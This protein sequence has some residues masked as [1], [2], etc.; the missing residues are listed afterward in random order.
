[1]QSRAHPQECVDAYQSSERIRNLLCYKHKLFG[2]SSIRGG[3]VKQIPFNEPSMK[4]DCDFF[5][6]PE[7]DTFLD[8]VKNLTT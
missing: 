7:A 3:L 4:D 6:E 1:M 5:A 8:P 2:T